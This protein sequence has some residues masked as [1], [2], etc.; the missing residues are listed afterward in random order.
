MRLTCLLTT[1]TKTSLNLQKHQKQ[2]T[3][4]QQKPNFWCVLPCIIP[5]FK[6]PQQKNQLQQTTTSVPL[7]TLKP[8]GL[9]PGVIPYLRSTL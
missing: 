5:Y 9:N 2:P 3:E 1:R 8:F 4:T 6:F 7:T